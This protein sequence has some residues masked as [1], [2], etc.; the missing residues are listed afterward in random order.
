MEKQMNQKL[1]LSDLAI[2]S[3]TTTLE[4]DGKEKDTAE[5]FTN[6]T[7]GDTEPPC[8]IFEK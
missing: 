5:G 8:C 2:T 7:G 3:F 1:N 4:S 6:F